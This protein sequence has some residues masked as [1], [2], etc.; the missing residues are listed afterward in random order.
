MYIWYLGFIYILWKLFP[1]RHQISETY[2]PRVAIMIPTRNEQ[3]NISARIQNCLE[4]DYPREKLRILVVDSTSTDGT[5]NIVGSFS[6]Q[7]VELLQVEHRWKAYA[8]E[9]GI[10]FLTD[11]EVVIS[12]DAN[13]FF[14]Q[15]VV[16]VIW[17]SITG[18]KE[19]G[20]FVKI[21]VWN[22]V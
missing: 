12:T 13:A 16:Q 17:Y 22:V 11:T 4:L 2:C 10:E 15:D 1:K 18:K 3:L 7:W 14:A 19:R 6:H 9:K 5:Q 20:N 21:N 8:M